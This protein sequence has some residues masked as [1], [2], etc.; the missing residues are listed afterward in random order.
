MLRQEEKGFF[1]EA[2]RGEKKPKKKNKG[3][4]LHSWLCGSKVEV[5]IKRSIAESSAKRE[6][7]AVSLHISARYVRYLH[8]TGGFCVRFNVSPG[9][10][11]YKNCAS[12]S[13]KMWDQIYISTAG[14]S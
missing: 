13:S 9:P 7:S 4:G 1:Y 3:Y 8:D 10:L 11:K 14:L 6:G 2:A 5:L 12:K